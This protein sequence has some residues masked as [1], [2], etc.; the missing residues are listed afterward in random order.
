MDI[1]RWAITL[2]FIV[3]SVPCMAQ[4]INFAW[5]PHTQA[6]DLA[7]FKLYQGK[8]A[9]TYDQG[10]VATFTGGSLTTGSIPVPKPGRYYWVLTAFTPDSI[11]SDFSN[12]V[13]MVVKPKPPK[14]NSVTQI[15]RGISKAATSVA[16]IFAPGTNLKVSD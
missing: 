13:T 10:L 4:T 1:R 7:G 14:I 2:M 12:E 9:G 6:A 3:L 8:T 15:A 16:K 5:D 11:E